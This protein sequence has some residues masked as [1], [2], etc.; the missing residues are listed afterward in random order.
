[1]LVLIGYIHQTEKKKGVNAF[2]EARQCS[3]MNITETK[4]LED[5]PIEDN[6]SSHGK[7][8]KEIK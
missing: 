1:M 6:D 8:E 5:S 4:L 7:I 3:C 2:V